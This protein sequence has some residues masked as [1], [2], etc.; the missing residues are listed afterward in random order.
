MSR[1]SKKKIKAIEGLSVSH[2]ILKYYGYTWVD[3]PPDQWHKHEKELYDM[4]IAIEM[5]LL[6][7]V[8]EILETI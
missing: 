8:R 3:L 6:E 4:V 5:K 2:D 7:S 1:V